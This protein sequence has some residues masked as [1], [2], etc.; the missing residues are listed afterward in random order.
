MAETYLNVSKLAYLNVSKPRGSSTPKFGMGF[1]VP[2]PNLK[3]RAKK[4]EFHARSHAKIMISTP[5]PTPKLSFHAKIALAWNLAWKSKSHA[6]RWGS[7]AKIP[8]QVHSGMEIWIP[9]LPNG[10]PRQNSMQELPCHGR[11]LGCFSSKCGLGKLHRLVRW[12]STCLI[13]CK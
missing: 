11:P 9:R 7:H 12:N 4:N 3:F 5:N 13:S 1:R 8:R 2:T 6:S 10:I